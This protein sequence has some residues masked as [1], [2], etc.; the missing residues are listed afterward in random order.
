MSGHSKWS[1]I[2]RSKGIAD[3]KRGQQFTKLGKAIAVAVRG[4]GGVAD[5]NANFQLRLAIEKA[6]QFNMPKANIDRAVQR[7]AGKGEGSELVEISYEGYGP[8]GIAVLVEVATDNKQ[9][10]GQEIRNLFEKGG[11][12]LGGPGSVSFQFESN[13]YLEIEKPKQA[14]ETLLK[15]IDLGAEDVEEG[16]DE[17]EIYVKP[18]ELETWK[19]LLQK[20]G[21]N[22][23]S[24]ELLM[25]PKNLLK[26]TEKQSAAKVL[27][28]M[29]KLQ[30]H[31]D[32]QKVSANFDIPDDVL[33]Q[34]EK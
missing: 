15:L 21:F 4:G 11:G 16:D 10:T 22:L 14:E 33:E 19:Q 6:K 7:G 3:T 2:H 28:F 5:P 31:D 13:G 25:K 34:I 18:E 26:I 1:K 12:N 24:Y 29:N 30:D 23:K 17:I 20:E 27:N 8:E 9:R 32:V